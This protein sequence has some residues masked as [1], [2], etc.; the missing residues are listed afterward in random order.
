MNIP[1]NMASGGYDLVEI[2]EME[3]KMKER[4]EAS[5]FGGDVVI[6]PPSPY[7]RHQRWKLGHTKRT[8]G[9]LFDAAREIIERIVHYTIFSLS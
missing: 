2:R 1:H 4:Q 8:G 3:R 9:L 7:T 5:K 6:D